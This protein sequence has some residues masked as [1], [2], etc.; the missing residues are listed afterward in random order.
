MPKQSKKYRELRA[1]VDRTQRFSIPEAVKFIR[2]NPAAKFDETV[3][4]HFRLGVDPRKADQNIRGTVLLPHGLGKTVR[5]LVFAEGEKEKEAQEAGADHVGCDDLIERIT[6]EG[7][8]DFDVAIATPDVMK[9]VGRLG[10]Q[11]GP[12]GL[13]PNPKA[14]TVTFEVSNAVKEFK[15]GKVEYRVDKFGNIHCPVGKVSFDQEL[16]EENITQLVEAVIKAR[17]AAA[18]GTYLK[19]AVLASTMGPGVRLDTVALTNL[20]Q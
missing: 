10:K 13:M 18:K 17:P 9:K 5:V 8:F 19:N 16:L 1:K 6:K 11:L 15:A 12:R 14:G 3:E 2:E 4:V 7:W 20:G